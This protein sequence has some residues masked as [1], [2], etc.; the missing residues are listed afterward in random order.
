VRLLGVPP[1]AQ[2][3]FVIGKLSFLSCCAALVARWWWPGLVWLRHP[4]L[5]VLGGVMLAAGVLLFVA[6]LVNLGG[7]TRM[8]LPAERTALK[9]QGVYRFTR[10]PMYTGGY[11]LCLAAV[12]WTANA[13][14]LALALAAVVIHHRIV[15]A[16]ERYLAA[17]FGE[18]YTQ[19]AGRVRRY[20]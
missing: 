1:I 11:L 17:Q 13:V 9:T 20:L 2:P 10:N 7:S 3:A 19:Y 16:E 8:G 12:L 18:A 14:I 15:L 5:D 6:G 4:A